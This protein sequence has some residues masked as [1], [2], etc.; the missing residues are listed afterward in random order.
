MLIISEKEYH[1]SIKTTDIKGVVI[2]QERKDLVSDQI[3]SILNEYDRKVQ[4]Y[5]KWF[6]LLSD[7]EAS[8]N[9]IRKKYSTTD[10]M[11]EVIFSNDILPNL[12]FRKDLQALLFGKVVDNYLKETFFGSGD[13]PLLATLNRME[14]L[15]S[16]WSVDDF[17]ILSEQQLPSSVEVNEETLSKAKQAVLRV[18]DKF[19]K[20]MGYIASE[21]ERFGKRY[22]QKDI[23]PL[24]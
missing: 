24:K 20:S 1:L 10:F 22:G 8:E 13:L 18:I 15:I 5:W 16:K 3:N 11:L 2:T 14:F 6:K 12:V 7:G 4:S 19:I 21:F 17:R 9:Y 23:I